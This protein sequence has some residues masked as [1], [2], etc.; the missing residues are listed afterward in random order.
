MEKWFSV[1][2]FSLSTMD[3]EVHPY[4]GDDAEW[5]RFVSED[6]RNGTIFNLRKFLAYH[7]PDRFDDHSLLFRDWKGRLKAVLPAAIVDGVLV[8]HPG[9][10]YGGLVLG[11]NAILKNVY[12]AIGLL[13]NHAENFNLKAIELRPPPTVFQKWPC[14]DLDYALWRHGFKVV[15]MPLTSVADLRDPLPMADSTKRSIRK[16]GEC[17]V[18]KQL[19]AWPHWAWFWRILRQNLHERHDAQPTH[20]LWEML[21]LKS[22][23]PEA[24]NLWGAFMDDL[25]VAGMVTFD[26]NGEALLAFYYATD[27]EYQKLRPLNLVIDRVMWWAKE[28][29][30]KWLNHGISTEEG[31]KVANWGLFRF[32]EGFGA[33][34]VVRRHW[35]LEL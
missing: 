23:F 30:Y 6:S 14:E 1:P 7:P 21:E 17:L 27:Y 34:G 13:K 11:R 9:A 31:G 28:A 8:S 10:S 35:R 33:S 24:I 2:R 19:E 20:N 32:K 26:C 3:I 12:E 5:D 4:D 25:L 16:A 15:R 18:V 29:G 22:L